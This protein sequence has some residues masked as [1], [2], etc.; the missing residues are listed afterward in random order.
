MNSA[1]FGDIY[2]TFTIQFFIIL[3]NLRHQLE[4][5]ILTQKRYELKKNWNSRIDFC[6]ELWY[7]D[8]YLVEMV[9]VQRQISGILDRRDLR[10]IFSTR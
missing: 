2:Y 5:Q 8:V 9:G 1:F 7:F 4:L 3:R 10:R 6:V